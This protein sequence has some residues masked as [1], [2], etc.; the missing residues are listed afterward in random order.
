MSVSQHIP[1]DIKRACKC[2]GYAAWLDTPDAWLGLPIALAA[3]LEPHQRAALAY[4]A[5]SSLNENDAYRT[6]S[7]AIF[8]TFKVE[9][10]S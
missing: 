4:A 8:G 5:L 9:V 6:A 3:R 1:T 2:I 7:L 10:A